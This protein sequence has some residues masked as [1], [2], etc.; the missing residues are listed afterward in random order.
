VL[1]PTISITE[2]PQKYIPEGFNQTNLDEKSK[3]KMVQMI[4]N[5]I[6]AQN[7]RDRKKA[8]RK[9]LEIHQKKI[10]SENFQ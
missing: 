3:K 9:K 6:S 2:I 4:R 1:T 7:S 5:R 10:A 8:Y